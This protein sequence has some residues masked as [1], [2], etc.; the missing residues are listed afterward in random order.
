MVFNIQSGAE[1]EVIQAWKFEADEVYCDRSNKG[2]SKDC[3]LP[4]K[5]LV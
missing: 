2:L 5:E 3:F 1:L 4:S